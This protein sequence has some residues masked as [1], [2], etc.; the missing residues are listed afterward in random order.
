M[1]ILKSLIK[2]FNSASIKTIVII[3]FL[4]FMLM[5]IGIT[6]FITYSNWIHSENENINKTIISM[7]E[8]IKGKIDAIVDLPLNINKS[9]YNLLEKNVIDIKDES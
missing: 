3:V 7:N 9:N 4:S 5:T 1:K 8:E 2:T 6:S